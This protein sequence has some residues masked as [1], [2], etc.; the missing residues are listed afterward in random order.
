[1]KN[2]R[3]STDQILIVRFLSKN[4]FNIIK[5]ILLIYIGE[6][7]IVKF[8]EKIVISFRKKKYFDINVKELLLTLL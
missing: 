7:I 8:C 1:M 2:W 3:Y 5:K 6:N 4:Y